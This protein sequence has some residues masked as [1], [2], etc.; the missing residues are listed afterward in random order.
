[1][2]QIGLEETKNKFYR[3]GAESSSSMINQ[4]L[5]KLLQS[6]CHIGIFYPTRCKRKMGKGKRQEQ[7]KAQD[8]GQDKE[9][10]QT[11]ETILQ[12]GSWLNLHQHLIFRI[13]AST[14]LKLCL[15][16]F[17]HSGKRSSKDQ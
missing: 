17:F 3:N 11:E 13:Q 2:N 6:L 10:E 4:S 16:F 5:S 12:V 15:L 14:L 9:Q 8:N 1:L 7:D